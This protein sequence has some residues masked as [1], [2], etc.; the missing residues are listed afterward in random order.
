MLNIDKLRKN[1]LKKLI[2]LGLGTLLPIILIIVLEI[3]EK[4]I[5]PEFE[6]LYDLLMVRSG[7]FVLIECYLGIK[8]SKYIKI[9]TNIDFAESEVRRI[10]DERNNFIEHKAYRLVLKFGLYAVSIAMI[11]AAF[12]N[13]YIFYTLGGVVVFGII[14]YF[15]VNLYY[16]KKY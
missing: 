2:V 15:F 16:M 3:I 14:T 11:V 13:R 9:L 12:I 6:V 10:N 8:I 1:S 5:N 7:V 4:R